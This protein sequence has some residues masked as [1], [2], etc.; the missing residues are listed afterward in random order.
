MQLYDGDGNLV[1]KYF[2]FNSDLPEGQ[3]GLEWNGT[4]GDDQAVADGNYVFYYK[5]GSLVVTRMIK[6]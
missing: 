2:D 1:R 6:K 5:L 3:F 4:D